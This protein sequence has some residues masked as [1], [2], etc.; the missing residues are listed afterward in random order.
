[1]D[2]RWRFPPRTI[3]GLPEDGRTT[4]RTTKWYVHAYL[5]ADDPTVL[6]LGEAHLDELRFGGKRNYG[7]GESRVKDT[8]IV[9]LDTLDYSSVD[10]ADEHLIELLT[11]FVIRTAYP[12]VDDAN[13]PWW[14][15]T[16]THGPV[17]RR[18]E[19]IVHQRRSHSLETV[20]HGQVIAYVGDEPLQTAVNG[21]QRVGPHAKYGF[22][23]F[24][25]IP[26]GSSTRAQKRQYSTRKKGV[27]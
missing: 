12:G 14:W 19:R 9:E 2:P 10:A 7:Y 21:I 17:R 1:M 22:G 27:D 26:L 5:Q 25:V 16:D 3:F 20:D 11:P 23:E 15:D 18:E 24:R 6:P 8:R 13:I 4:K